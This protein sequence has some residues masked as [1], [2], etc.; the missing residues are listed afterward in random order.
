MFPV[1]GLDGLLEVLWLL[2]EPRGV[3]EASLDVPQLNFK[4]MNLKHT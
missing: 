1:E 4:V 3:M 2:D